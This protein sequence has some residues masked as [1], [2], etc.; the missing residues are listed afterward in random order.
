MHSRDERKHPGIKRSFLP[1]PSS[2]EG[3]QCFCIT[4]PAGLDNKKALIDLLTIPT[5]WFYWDKS[6][7]DYSA[8]VAHRWRDLLDLPGGIEMSCCC[9]SSG[10]NPTRFNAA[11]ELEISFDGGET[12]QPFPQG[13]PRINSTTSPPLPGADGND[14]KCIA[15]QGVTAFIDGQFIDQ[16]ND[17]MTFAELVT[18]MLSIIG[19]LLSGGSAAPILL[20]LILTIVGGIVTV[21]ATAIQG[22]FDATQEGI[23]QCIMYCNMKPDGSFDEAGWQGVKSDIIAQMDILCA[24]FIRDVVNTMGAVGLTNA[25]RSGLTTGILDCSG[26]D[27]ADCSNLENWSVIFGTVL[28]QTPGYMRLSA[29]DTL[30]ATRI[31]LQSAI[32]KCC[33]VTYE[34]LSGTPTNQAYL[35]CGSNDPV[36]SVPPPETCMWDINITDV[37]ERPFEVEFFFTDCP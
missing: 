23:L 33:A 22:A 37:F 26:C 6:D 24:E 1:L 27:C 9:G 11:G 7:D 18:L 28:E 5:Y 36:F 29:E 8:Q 17:A 32:D 21:T 25:A 3:E 35:P 16:I 20:P 15:A 30:G 19:L 2:I 4:I 14:K 12:W 34:V 10:G 13:D 31:R